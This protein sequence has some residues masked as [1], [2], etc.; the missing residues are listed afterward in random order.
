M[1]NL[2]EVCLIDDDKVTIMLT[3]KRV[4][5]ANF[6][7]NIT[8]YENGKKAYDNFA[9][10]INNNIALPDLILLDINM[11]IW[12]GWDFL[13]EFSKINNNPRLCLFMM[14]SSIDPKDKEKALQYPIVKDFLVKPIDENTLLIALDKFDLKNT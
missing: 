5:I 13:D 11:P 6:C 7:N 2:D 4:N 12:D 1:R 10:R 8:S 14:T 3:K 9:D